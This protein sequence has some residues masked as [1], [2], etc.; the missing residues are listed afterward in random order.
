MNAKSTIF[1]AISI[2]GLSAPSYAAHTPVPL[3]HPGFT[4]N[5][6]LPAALNSLGGTSDGFIMA[7]IPTQFGV[8]ISEMTQLAAAIEKVQLARTAHAL[9]I[10]VLGIYLTRCGW[11]RYRNPEPWKDLSDQV[12]CAASFFGGLILVC[13][14]PVIAAIAQKLA[15]WV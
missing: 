11:N 1:I 6:T 8:S 3:Q 5:T 4:V 9:G 14:A 15:N 12:T 2:I 13:G 7:K 10:V